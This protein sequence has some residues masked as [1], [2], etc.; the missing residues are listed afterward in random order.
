MGNVI[1]KILSSDE[2]ITMRDYE[3]TV[4]NDRECTCVH[5]LLCEADCTCSCDGF[6]VYV[7]KK[8]SATVLRGFKCEVLDPNMCLVIG[9]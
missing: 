1:L 5:E 8:D 3:F 7:C 9:R 4:V 2:E 6:S